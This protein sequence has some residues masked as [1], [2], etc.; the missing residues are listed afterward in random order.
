[1]FEPTKTPDG[2]LLSKAAVQSGKDGCF[3]VKAV[4]L[5]ANPVMIFKNQR[6]GIISQIEDM[7]DPFQCQNT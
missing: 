6:T 2:V 5:T 4:N 1:M 3:W 7:S